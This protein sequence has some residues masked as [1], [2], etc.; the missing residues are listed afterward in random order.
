M[1]RH[2]RRRSG[3]TAVVLGT[4]LAVNASAGSG[5]TGEIERAVARFVTA[6]D[7]PGAVGAVVTP[8]RTEYFRLGAGPGGAPLDETTRIG[9]H[10]IT[11]PFTVIALMTLVREGKIALDDPATRFL[12]AGT[13]LPS[14]RGQ[15]I[16]IRHLA[17]H[18]SALPV[19]RAGE[20]MFESLS[21]WSPRAWRIGFRR[22]VTDR[23]GGPLAGVTWDD[24][25]AV[26]G[27]A[28]LPR[29]PGS[30]FEYC[31]IG[32]GLLGHIVGRVDGRGYE[33][34]VA[35][36]VW[37]PLGLARTRLSL[38]RGEG[39][40][41]MFLPLGPLAPAGGA[42]SCAADLASFMRWCLAPP[43]GSLADALS[44]TLPDAGVDAAGRPL[45]LGWLPALRTARAAFP[46]RWYHAGGTHAFAGFDR[47]HRVGLVLLCGKPMKPAEELGLALLDRLAGGTSAIPAPRVAIDLP[48]TALDRRTGT[49]RLDAGSS[50]VIT[51]AGERLVAQFYKQG[52]AGGK[53]S[54]WSESS[55]TFFCREWDCTVTFSPDGAAKIRMYGWE[56]SYTPAPAPE[57]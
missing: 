35:N 21:R 27:R 47:A 3:W 25:F 49:Y 22:Y 41:P 39:R 56:G 8:E 23:S 24:L 2:A 4:V 37:T 48:T 11:K 31:N 6:G 42:V 18:T 43:P 19:G 50:V 40:P 45:R 17:T 1:G 34:A 57:R 28:T 20:S 16:T 55:T 54:L 5:M 36:R 10:S 51:R 13:R 52:K 15:A 26:L 30:Q 14:F 38:V 29:A 46:A 44:L 7:I 33:T 53:A 12:P 9:I 32:L